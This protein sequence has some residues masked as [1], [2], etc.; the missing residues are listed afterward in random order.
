VIKEIGNEVPKYDLQEEEEELGK[1][2]SS[3][4]WDYLMYFR[5][6]INAVFVAL[7]F[8]FYYFLSLAWNLY[9][10]IYFNHWWAQFNVYLL[11][12]TV[13]NLWQGVNAVYLAFEIPLYLRT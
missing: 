13:Y 7:P 2:N 5:W 4:V 3:N 8:M 11:A 1:L 9:I 12:N 6:V 10:N